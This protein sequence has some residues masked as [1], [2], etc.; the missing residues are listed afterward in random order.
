V[1]RSG[2][3]NNEARN[4]RCANR[5]GTHR[6]LDAAQGFSRRFRFCLSCDV[7]QFFPSI[8]HAILLQ[9]LAQKLADPQ[10][11]WLCQKILSS[12]VGVLAE[13][14]AMVYFPGDDLLAALRP[15]GLPI[16]NLTSQ[17]WANVYLNS[18]DHFVLR[19]LR[20]PA[21]VR[22]VDDLLLFSNDKAELWGWKRALVQRLMRLRLTI[23]AGAHPKPVA[24]GIPFL[25]FTVFPQRRRLKRRKGIHFQCK[26]HRLLAAWARGELSLEQVQ[27]SVQGWA[28]HV[29]YGNTVG[30]RKAV[31]GEN[32]V[33]WLK[34]QRV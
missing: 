7:V 26:L 2:S 17:F 29:R 1:L 6:A 23:H 21:Y 8:D 24:E 22:Y 5:K 4:V 33:Y 19:E 28:N 3:F 27:P 13:Q 9:F 15:R 14:Y 12:G 16:G 25:G 32:L 31:L 18:L 34:K 30:L 20:C 10:V 11:L